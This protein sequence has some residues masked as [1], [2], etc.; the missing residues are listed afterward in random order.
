MYKLTEFQPH[1]TCCGYK[2]LDWIKY[3][4]MKSKALGGLYDPQILSHD[5]NFNIDEVIYY[6]K[7]FKLY[8]GNTV[9]HKSLYYILTHRDKLMLHIHFT[10]NRRSTVLVIGV[11]PATLLLIFL[12]IL[13]FVSLKHLQ[14]YHNYSLIIGRDHST[15]HENQDCTLL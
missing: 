9:L 12:H 7:K 10:F 8:S 15:A 1:Q 3:S 11:Q 6:W 2:Q 13:L 5:T 4:C 14:I